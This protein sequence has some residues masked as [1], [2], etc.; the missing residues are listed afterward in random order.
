LVL[1]GEGKA[2][3]DGQTIS[4]TIKRSAR[5]RQVRLEVRRDTSLT[6]V[7]PKSYNLGYLSDLLQDKRQWILSK[8]AQCSQAPLLPAEKAPQSGDTIPYLGRDVEVVRRRSL[9]E[10][11]SAKLEGERLIVNLRGSRDGSLGPVLEQ[12]YR[13]QAARLIKGRAEELS[14]RL[15]LPYSRLIIRGQRTR[16]GSCSQRGTLSFNWKLMMAPPPVIDYVI[17][18]ELAHLKEMNHTSRFWGLVA[19]HCPQWRQHKRWLKDHEADLAS[20]LSS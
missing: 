19:E 10:A 13:M 12:W 3:L 17:L 1:V 14:A 6:V 7:L 4:Y 15:G 2:S 8:L 9:E 18:H 20:T 16:W 5:A 11:E